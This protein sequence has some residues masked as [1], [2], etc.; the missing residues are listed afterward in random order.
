VFIVEEI[1]KLHEAGTPYEQIA[2]LYRINARSEPFEE[3]LADAGIPYQVRDGAF[4]RRPGPR[5]VLARLQRSTGSPRAA[6]EAATDALG[7]DP[8]REPEDAEEVTRQADLARLRTLAAE[9]DAATPDADVAAFLREL[10][11]RFSAEESGRG[12]NLL[13]LHRSKGLE[14]EAVFLPRLLEGEIPFKAG[15]SVSD[16]REERRLLYV[17]ITRAKT[18]LY[19]SWPNEAKSKPSPFL[20]ELGAGDVARAAA[21]T[22]PTRTRVAAPAGDGPLFERLKAWRRERAKADGVPAYVVF[23]DATLAL[24]AEEQPSN[25]A[26]LATVSGV[27]P[28]KLDRYADEI[29]EIVGAEA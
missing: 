16:P 9:F 27:G 21:R 12:V 6:V 13:T 23:H 7:F 14:F 11:K 1:R 4:L 2:V 17:G 29:L 22:P 10:A 18:H 24:I 15:R 19:L 8:G 20:V 26:A 25:R 3:A 28:T 5:S